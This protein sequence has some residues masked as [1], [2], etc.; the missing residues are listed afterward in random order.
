MGNG[1]DPPRLLTNA[2]YQRIKN[3]THVSGGTYDGCILVGSTYYWVKPNRSGTEWDL[4]TGKPDANQTEI[5]ST[6][7]NQCKSGGTLSWNSVD[8]VWENG[9]NSYRWAG[10]AGGYIGLAEV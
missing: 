5:T 1:S 9:G 2:D 10:P 4:E 3:G 7:W 6:V 8:E